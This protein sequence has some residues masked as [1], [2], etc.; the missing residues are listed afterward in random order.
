M[1]KLSILGLLAIILFTALPAKAVEE[2]TPLA[3]DPRIRVVVYNENEVFKFL[4]HYGYQSVIEFELG[5]E[6]IQT[7]SVGDST[8]WQ[9]VPSGDRLFVKPIDKNATTNMTLITN[10][11]VYNFELH[12]AE[13]ADIQDP[14]MIFVMRFKYPGEQMQ[15][16]S[17]MDDVPIP[18]LDDP[19]KYNFG[20]SLTGSNVIAPIRIFDDGVFTY[21]QFRPNAEVPAFFIVNSDG[22]EQII[23]YRARGDYIVIERTASQY[24]LRLGPDI[25][26]VYNDANPLRITKKKED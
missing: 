3:I 14:D 25:V 17:R 16:G 5:K 8:A 26:C 12:A 23:N 7:V 11:R 20:Y 15:F 4:G 13:T 6:T 1:K 21:F 9:I 19:S 24:T 22:R 18:E 2:S 10:L